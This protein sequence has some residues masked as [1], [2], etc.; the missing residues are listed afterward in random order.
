MPSPLGPDQEIN[1]QKPVAVLI[2]GMSVSAADHF[3]Y[4]MKQIPTAR[5]FGLPTCGAFGNI[6]VVSKQSDPFSMLV[7]WSQVSD[8]NGMMQGRSVQPH[9]LIR[10]TLEDLLGGEDTVM[11][12]AVDWVTE[13]AALN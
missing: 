8:Q 12:A 1:I 3:A 10:P 13:Q 2:S 9:E 11:Q 6:S 4:L 5:L 7:T